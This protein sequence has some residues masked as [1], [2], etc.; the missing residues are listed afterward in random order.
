MPSKRKDRRFDK[1][2]SNKAKSDKSKPS[3]ATE[4]SE[5]IWGGTQ[6]HQYRNNEYGELEYN[7]HPGTAVNDYPQENRYNKNEEPRF[8]APPNGSQC[9]CGS[10]CSSNSGCVRSTKFGDLEQEKRQPDGGQDTAIPIPPPISSYQWPQQNQNSVP[11]YPSTRSSYQTSYTGDA[12]GRQQEHSVTSSAQ[13]APTPY[14]SSA[15]QGIPWNDAM[16]NTS[17]SGYTNQALYSTYSG[18]IQPFQQLAVQQDG[19][20]GADTCNDDFQG[21]SS[22]ATRHSPLDSS[23]GTVFGRICKEMGLLKEDYWE[24]PD[25]YEKPASYWN[26]ERLQNNCVFVSVG[27]LLGMP[28]EELSSYLQAKPL[29]TELQ[30]INLGEI[31][32]ILYR[33][34]GLNIVAFP[35]QLEGSRRRQ[36]QHPEPQQRFALRKLPECLKDKDQ[37]FAIGYERGSGRGHCVVAQNLRGRGGTRVEDYQFTCFQHE[38][39]GRN[40]SEDVRNSFISFAIFIDPGS[41]NR[42][43]S[44]FYESTLQSNGSRGAASANHVTLYDDGRS[45]TTVSY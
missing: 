10:G 35:V 2:R 16:N 18:I 36:S 39:N 28:S 6:W 34:P 29:P 30:G 37:P 15:A 42:A 19:P 1:H 9:G 43:L 20:Y 4:W 8:G 40:M 41:R 3:Q 11:T 44:C 22:I 24:Y 7:T 25:R 27:Y 17:N 21:H 13:Y 5:W 45:P 12:H 31:E 33:I 38:T 14:S 23:H 32:R 26:G